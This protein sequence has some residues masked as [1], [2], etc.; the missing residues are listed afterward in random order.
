M[1]DAYHACLFDAAFTCLPPVN[2]ATFHCRY[3][4][5]PC[6]H[7]AGYNMML[8]LIFAAADIAAAFAADYAAFII[9]AIA[10]AAERAPPRC[11]DAA[12][13]ASARFDADSYA[14][15][16]IAAFRC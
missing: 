16:V 3:A 2:A 14:A 12:A 5:L 15:Y 4:L 7:S 8:L 13:I 11:F 6:C 1:R 9:I 10:A